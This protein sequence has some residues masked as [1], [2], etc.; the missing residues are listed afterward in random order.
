MNIFLA[1]LVRFVIFK[2]F[3][4]YVHKV[5]MIDF[6]KYSYLTRYTQVLTSFTENIRKFTTEVSK[7]ELTYFCQMLDMMLQ[8]SNMNS[9]NPLYQI[10]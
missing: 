10:K 6:R 4:L 3:T 2:H 1:L 8:N 7:N 9:N 5:W